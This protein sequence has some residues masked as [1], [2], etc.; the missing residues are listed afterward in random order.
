MRHPHRA[1]LCAAAPQK[2]PQDVL[3][4]LLHGLAGEEGRNE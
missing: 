1:A 4:L 2:L 3:G